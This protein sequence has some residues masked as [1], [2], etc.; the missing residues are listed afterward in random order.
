MVVINAVPSID[1]EVKSYLLVS[2]IFQKLPAEGAFCT[3]RAIV[4]L[5]LSERQN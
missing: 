1:F 4:S 5:Q 2:K 3:L